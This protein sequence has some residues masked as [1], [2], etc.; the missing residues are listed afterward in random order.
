MIDYSIV[1]R[2]PVFGFPDIQ[3]IWKQT[4]KLRTRRPKSWWYDR[5]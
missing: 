1:S 3:D 4:D 2:H 5:L